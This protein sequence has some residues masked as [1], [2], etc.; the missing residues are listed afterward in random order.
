MSVP[1]TFAVL[2]GMEF[3]KNVDKYIKY[4]IMNIDKGLP[5]SAVVPCCVVKNNRNFWNGCGYFFMLRIITW[6]PNTVG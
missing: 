6:N 1:R 2:C 4:A 5:N 3:Y